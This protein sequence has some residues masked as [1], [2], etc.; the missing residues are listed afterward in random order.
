[1]TNEFTDNV[2]YELGACNNVPELRTNYNPERGAGVKLPL[3]A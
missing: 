3:T 1:M 2:S